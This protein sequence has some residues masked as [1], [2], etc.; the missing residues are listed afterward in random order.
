[1]VVDISERS[2]EDAIE[3][4]FLQHG[5]DAGRQSL[6]L[7]EAVSVLAMCPEAIAVAGPTTSCRSPADPFDH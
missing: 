6:G 4:G 7:R 3:Q 1:M 2:F 5:P